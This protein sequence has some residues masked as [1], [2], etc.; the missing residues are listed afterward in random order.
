MLSLTCLLVI[1]VGLYIALSLQFMYSAQTKNIYDSDGYIERTEKIKLTGAMVARAF[2]WPLYAFVAILDFIMDI[3]GPMLWLSKTE[4]Y[5][6]STFK[7]RI[8]KFM[9]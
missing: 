3:V 1:L 5:R 7:K 2:S 4:D 6:D 8:D 9:E